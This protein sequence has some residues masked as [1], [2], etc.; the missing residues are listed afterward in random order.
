VA[1]IDV[2]VVPAISISPTSAHVGDVITVYGSNLYNNPIAFDGAVLSASETTYGYPDTSGNSMTFTVPSTATIGYHTVQVQRRTDGLSDPLVL[3][4]VS[5]VL[6][7]IVGN[8]TGASCTESALDA[9]LPTGG[10]VTF[11]CGGAATITVTSTKSSWADTTIDG[12]SLMTISGG[13][14]VRVFSVNP[15]VK[16]TVKNLTIANGNTEGYGGGISNDGTLR[17]GNSFFS[18]GTLSVTNC[19][20]SGNSADRGGGGDIGANSMVMVTNSTFSGNSADWGG[21]GDIGANSMVMV[22]NS[23]FSGN[24]ADWG[25]GGGGISNRILSGEGTRVTNTILANSTSGGNCDGS[26]TD[27]GH[28]IDDGTTCGFGAANGSLNNTNPNLDPAGLANNGGPTQTIALQASS[29]AINAGDESVCSTTT[30]T[31]PVGNLDQR[32]YVRPGTGAA[33]CSIGAFEANLTA[34]TAAKLVYYALGDSIAA[35]YGLPGGEGRTPD[36]PCRRSPNAYPWLVFQ[37]LQTQLPQ[38]STSFSSDNHL[39]CS[40]AKSSFGYGSADMSQQVAKVQ[41]SPPGQTTL[42]SLSVGADDF[43][44]RAE[45]PD[46]VHI[47]ASD[48]LF[49]QW[50]NDTIR[51]PA[52]EPFMG[53]QASLAHWLRALLKDDHTFVVVTDYFNPFN[54]ASNYFKL[55]KAEQLIGLGASPFKVIYSPRRSASRRAVDT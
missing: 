42:V 18:G 15:G 14:R 43:D 44:F 45:I 17:V 19:T 40:G 30:G 32:G 37:A 24:S 47:C 51:G 50:V 20:F 8:G 5:R 4:V 22:T 31:A 34:P 46:P 10:T 33:N 41:P 53:V 55:W 11:N 36:D 21:G 3:R 23:T 9:C 27:G 13:N 29:P 39:A 7:C 49:M 35:G 38:Y 52:N 12:G 54:T 6:A 26:I 28:N 25:G 2:T 1:A 48:D 16:L